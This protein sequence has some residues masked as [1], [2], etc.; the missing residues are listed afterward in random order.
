MS[1]KETR[2]ATV[3]GL[4]VRPARGAAMREVSEAS[5]AL[6]GGLEGDHGKG[7]RR[8]VTLLA[9][10]AWREANQAL[11]CDLPWW[12]RRAN[13]LVEGVDLTELHGRHVRLGTLELD[14]LGETEPCGVM[15][16]A[17]S[18]LHDAL[19]VNGRGG[20]FGRVRVAGTVRVGDDVVVVDERADAR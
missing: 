2:P 15:E 3:R 4:A 7:G 10:E 14:V 12:T 8:G 13:V 17:R 20:V 9:L 18:G 16:V 6:D 1:T 11:G 5:A 19:A